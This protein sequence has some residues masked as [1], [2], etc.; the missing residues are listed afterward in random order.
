MKDTLAPHCAAGG[1]PPDEGPSPSVTV[2]GVWQAIG[3]T[4]AGVVGLEVDS[5]LGAG[6]GLGAGREFGAVG[7]RGILGGISDA[8]R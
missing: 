2:G 7:A 6:V 5:G 3:S 4:A 1:G 8:C